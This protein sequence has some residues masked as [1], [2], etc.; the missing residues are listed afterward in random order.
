[1]RPAAAAL[2]LCL[3]CSPAMAA[4]P[5]EGISAA[6]D[7]AAMRYPGADLVEIEGFAGTDGDIPCAGSSFS[8]NWHYKFHSS[9]GWAIVNACGPR[10]MNAATHYPSVPSAEPSQALPPSFLNSAAL[11]RK[12][13]KAGVFT[14]E[15]GGRDR[16]V[17]M[18]VRILPAKGERKAGCYW[19][20]SQG[21]RKA[22][23]ACDGSGAAALS[24]AP[25]AQAKA[26]RPLPKGGVQRAGAAAKGLAQALAVARA[27]HPGAKLVYAEALV[28][29]KG[30]VNCAANF[31]WQYVFRL[32]GMGASGLVTAGCAAPGP[33]DTDMDGRYSMAARSDLIP[34]Q[35]VDSDYAA[36]SMPQRCGHATMTMRLQNFRA[37]ETPV[38]GHTLL[39]TIECGIKKYYV[40]ARTGNYLG[41]SAK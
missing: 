10:V 38:A 36:D 20:V 28:S 4:G 24:K 6:K 3:A 11:L 16:D 14:P 25:A 8:N 18:N 21:P 39:W 2:L 15:P 33:L 7:E 31:Y 35:F 23:A 12:L 5:L 27:Q 9:G 22:I 30:L 26:A 17:L 32:P 41:I 29:P 40:D 37:A 13:A 19:T 1:M 34:E